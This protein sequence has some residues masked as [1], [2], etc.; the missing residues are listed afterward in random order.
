MDVFLTGALAS[1]F[2]V[3]GLFFLRFWRDTRDRLFLL[4]A[5][6]FGLMAVNRTFHVPWQDEATGR[7]VIYLIRFLAFAIIAIAIV[8]KN[9]ASRAPR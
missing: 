7:A 8:D 1:A 9:R 2:A 6:A 3:A 4:F 5:F